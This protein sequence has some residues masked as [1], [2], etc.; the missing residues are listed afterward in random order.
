MG[1]RDESHDGK[2][3]R[4]AAMEETC[5]AAVS[6]VE[7][8]SSSEGK[9]PTKLGVVYQGVKRAWKSLYSAVDGR[10]LMHSF[11]AGLALGLVSCGVLM[12]EVYDR[13]GKNVLWAVLTVV[14]VFECTVGMPLLTFISHHVH[15]LF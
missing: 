2:N 7:D 14:V 13:L 10:N 4:E 12:Q 11:K 5:D 3:D 9:A 6:C 1:S 15:S 8:E